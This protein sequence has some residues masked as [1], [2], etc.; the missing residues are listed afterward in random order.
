MKIYQILTEI[1]YKKL[2]DL[3]LAKM[4]SDLDSAGTRRKQGRGRRSDEEQGGMRRMEGKM[5]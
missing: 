2:G 1:C 5:E 4:V 3:I